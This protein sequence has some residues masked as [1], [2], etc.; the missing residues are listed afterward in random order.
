MNDFADNTAADLR[1]LISSPRFR[2]A[3]N[4][5]TRP[6]SIIAGTITAADFF[7]QAGRTWEV[8][9]FLDADETT[10]YEVN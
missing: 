1:A 7:A 3:Y 10:T 9:D 6:D 2:D 8:S 5:I 4:G